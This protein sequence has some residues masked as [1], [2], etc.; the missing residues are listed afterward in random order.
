MWSYYK[1]AV[2]ARSLKENNWIGGRT[3]LFRNHIMA[4]MHARSRSTPVAPVYAPLHAKTTHHQFSDAAASAMH[5]C[6]QLA[7]SSRDQGG[8]IRYR[9]KEM[10]KKGQDASSIAQDAL[11]ISLS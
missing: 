7:I 9:E 11:I 3:Q 8:I 5:A 10:K 2:L 1:H 6:M 4:Y